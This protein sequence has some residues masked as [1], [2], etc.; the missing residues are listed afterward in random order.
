MKQ[1]HQKTQINLRNHL[2]C[3]KAAENPH[4]KV[5]FSIHIYKYF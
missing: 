1:I 3:F 5:W 2:Q 4:I